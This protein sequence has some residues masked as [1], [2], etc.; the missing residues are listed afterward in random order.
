MQPALPGLLEWLHCG[1]NRS[2]ALIYI[3]PMAI[4]IIT[5]TT[6]FGLAD[7]YVGA[8]KGVILGLCPDA[9]IVDIS[10]EVE[11][12]AISEGAFVIAQA[13]RAFPENAIHVVVIDPGVGTARRP[14]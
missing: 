4:P 6:D 1:Q 5:L 14:I 12:F 13:Y 10:H 9:R 8:M 11:P 7:H 3:L 2:A